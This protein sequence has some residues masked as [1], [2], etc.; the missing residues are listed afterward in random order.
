MHAML[1]LERQ[2]Q[3]R[4]C[5]LHNQEDCLWKQVSIELCGKQVKTYLPALKQANALFFR[6][7]GF[8]YAL[9]KI[10]TAG[11][12]DEAQK[13]PRTPEKMS[14]YRA[15]FAKPMTRRHRV[16][17]IMLVMNIVRRPNMSATFPKGSRKAPLLNLYNDKTHE[18]NCTE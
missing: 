8:S 3:T 10:P 7:D 14:K 6:G 13:I 2:F 11:G 15:E 17:P 12:T 5:P 9:P 16:Y 1:R 18:P 4:A